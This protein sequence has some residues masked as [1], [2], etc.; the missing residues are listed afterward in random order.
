[1]ADALHRDLLTDNKEFDDLGW[2]G[3]WAYITTAPPRTALHHRANEGWTIADHLAAESLYEQ[4]KLGWRYT[5]M[6]FKHGSEAP[7][8][9]PISR[10]GVGDDEPESSLTWETATLDDLIPQ[11]VRDL[12]KGA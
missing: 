3:L 4:R 10:P 12:L 5:A 7:F 11:N 2:R 8:P 6:H 9:E 1:M